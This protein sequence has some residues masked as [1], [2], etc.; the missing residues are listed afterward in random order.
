MGVGADVGDPWRRIRDLFRSS[1][2]VMVVAV[3]VLF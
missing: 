1:G 2:V 3:V